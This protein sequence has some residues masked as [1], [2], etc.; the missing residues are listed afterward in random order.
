MY[1]FGPIVFLPLLACCVSGPNYAGPPPATPAAAL[2]P[3]V[4]GGDHVRADAPAAGPWWTALRDP[5]LDALEQRALTA[6]PNIGVARARVRQARAALRLDR[7][8]QLPSAGTQAIYV[9]ARLPEVDLGGGSPPDTDGAAGRDGG[10]TDAPNFYSLGFDAS[11]EVDL[12]GGQRRA[13]EAS[14][15]SLAAAEANIADAQVQLTAEIAQTYVRLRDRQTQLALSHRSADMQR[16]M[17][18]L[19]RQRLE[20]G[21]VS[22]VDVERVQTQLKSTVAQAVPIEAEI[23][24]LLNALAVLAGEQPGS[25]DAM[26]G[27]SG[28]V[29][30]VPAQ[31]SIGNPAALLQRRP[32]IRAA[33]RRLAAQTARIGVAEAA[34]FPKLS[35]MGILG[36]GGT[37]VSALTDLDNLAALAM[38]R[39]QWQFLDFGRNASRVEQSRGARDEAEAQY[40]Q[41]VLAALQDAED[42][43]ARFG[44]RRRT[45]ATL[46]EGKASADRAATLTRQR[47]QAGTATLIDVLDTER[48]RVSA[49]QSLAAALAELTN[50]YVAL[51]K[52]LGLGWAPT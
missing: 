20:R 21:A 12:F 42:A 24:T 49:E 14:R 52:A 36:L 44:T 10:G 13:V 34:R 47:F 15:A 9:H 39:L 27:D 41:T 16:Q 2:T 25:L 51:Q 1:R 29:P 48:A 23:A 28:A 43:L 22:A 50:D 11:W 45:V 35:F 18:A 37:S 7:A 31:V 30:L 46:A 6:N 3:F 8:N 19:T 32:D 5:V 33:E 40:R 17:L 4:R 26:L 38:P